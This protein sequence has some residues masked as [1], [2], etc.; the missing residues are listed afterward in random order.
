MSNISQDIVSKNEAEALKEMIFRR[1]QERA[2]NIA[3]ESQ[4]N[5]TTSVKYEIMDIARGSVRNSKNPFA[6]NISNEP[7]KTSSDN[8]VQPEEIK[9]E[10]MPSKLNREDIAKMKEKIEKG[11]QALREYLAENEVSDIMDEASNSLRTRKSFTGALEFL[12]SKASQSI[13]N[14]KSYGF[15]AIA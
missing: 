4:N 11:H 3:A 1:I 14:R 15:D 12:N 13:A 9:N 5:Y 8:K 6:L 7:Q 2:E 10:P